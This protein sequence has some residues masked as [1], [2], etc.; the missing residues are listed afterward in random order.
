LIE[1]IDEEEDADEE[2]EEEKEESKREENV[3]ASNDQNTQ[4]V[5]EDKH[6]SLTTKASASSNRMVPPPHHLHDIRRR[7]A[8]GKLKR[9]TNQHLIR[10]ILSHFQVA[11]LGLQLDHASYQ[12]ISVSSGMFE[13]SVYTSCLEFD[14]QGALLVGGSSNGLIALYDFDEYFHK[15]LN[16]VQQHRQVEESF[17][18]SNSTIATQ[19]NRND[20][21][22]LTDAQIKSYIEPVS[23]MHSDRSCRIILYYAKSSNSSVIFFLV[24]QFSIDSSHLHASRIKKVRW[25]PFNEDEIAS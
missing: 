14:A 24:S 17:C 15:S 12:V 20:D 11:P 25:N 2:E 4:N 5:V 10:W 9:S 13:S 23:W 16:M 18:R 7:E 8:Q 6:K 1:G 3:D 21:A 19:D 22:I